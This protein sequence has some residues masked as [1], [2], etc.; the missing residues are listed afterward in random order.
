MYRSG[1]LS[2]SISDH[3][4][5]EFVETIQQLITDVKKIGKSEPAS[6]KWYEIEQ[7]VE[8]AK[9]RA[10]VEEDNIGLSLIFAQILLNVFPRY[11]DN[12]DTFNL[13]RLVEKYEKST[14]EIEKQEILDELE[15]ITN[16][17]LILINVFSLKLSADNSKDARK[18]KQL[19]DFFDLA[20]KSIQSNDILTAISI[21]GQASDVIEIEKVD[22]SKG[23]RL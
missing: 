17:Y 14:I 15:E 19:M 5:S 23:I 4:K 18:A 12:T 20:M 9:E 1:F 13:S 7:K 3:R 21:L 8:R 22:Y 11:I 6:Q 16:N 2:E 10:K